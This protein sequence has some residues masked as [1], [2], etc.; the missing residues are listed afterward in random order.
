VSSASPPSSDAGGFARPARASDV[1]DLTRVQVGSWA[2]TLA[3]VVPAATL[4]ELTSEEASALWRDRWREAISNPPTSRHR[5][6]VAVADSAAPG[7][8]PAAREVVGLVS[9]GPATDADRWPGTDGEI[10]EFRVQPDRIAQG[11]G[12]RLLQAAADTLV[13]DGFRTMS[14]WVLATDTDV[15]RFLESSGWAADGARGEL[16]VG[17]SVPV[18]RLHTRL[19]E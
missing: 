1:D 5:V 19:S 13:A 11:H 4:A 7:S 2:C 9:A 10:Y 6:L 18:V 16:E 17:V 15:R 3:G 14:T 8:G 12:S